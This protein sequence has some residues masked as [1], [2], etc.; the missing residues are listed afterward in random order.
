VLINHELQEQLQQAAQPAPLPEE[1]YRMQINA[2]RLWQA[3]A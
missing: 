2:N 3:T 1:T